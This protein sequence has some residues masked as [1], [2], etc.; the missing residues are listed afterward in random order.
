MHEKKKKKKTGQMQGRR[1]LFQYV[2]YIWSVSKSTFC[3]GGYIYKLHSDMLIDHLAIWSA[4]CR[5]PHMLLPNISKGKLPDKNLNG[6]GGSSEYIRSQ[7][8]HW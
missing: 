4:C 6:Q 1:E 5:N 2:L 8:D 7:D 3:K